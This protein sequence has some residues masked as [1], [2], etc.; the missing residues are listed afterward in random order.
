MS[1]STHARDQLICFLNREFL[2]LTIQGTLGR[3]PTYAKSANDKD[4]D[5]V[6]KTLGE[7]LVSMGEIYIDGNVNDSIHLSNIVALSSRIKMS[8]GQYLPAVHFALVLH[9]KH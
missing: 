2:M 7:Y 8:M 4:R 6:R 5:S 3:N 1:N 9:R